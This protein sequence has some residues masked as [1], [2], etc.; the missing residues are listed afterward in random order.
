MPG[1]I[2]VGNVD[3]VAVLDMVPPAREPNMM[4]TTT[5]SQDWDSHQDC[6]E[7]G[8][9]QLYYLH[10]FLRSQGK[11]IMVDTGMGPGPHPDRGN[12]TGDLVNQLKSRGVETGDVD[13]VAHTHLHGDHVGW[14]VDYSGS[15]PAP[16]FPK[17]RYLVPRL[18]WE[19][20][21]KPD[22]IGSAPQVTNSVIPLEGMGVMDLVDS[23]YD[24]TDEVKTL[25]APGHT[26]GHM[27]IVITSQGEKAMVVGDLLH[28]KAQVVRPD[29]T[30]GV[31]TDKEASRSNRE[32]ILDD[33]EAEG[34]VIAAGHFHPDDHIG[35][36][37]RLDG[38]R[39]WQVL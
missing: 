38:R 36:V 17:A 27:V 6:L 7:E 12:R 11:V 4:F 19:H 33:A 16:T 18:D 9:L 14:N 39:Y 20:F 13:V 24:I 37:V 26:P 23:E 35:K 8:Q 29:W 1:R 21:T 34:F 2:T 10:F 28:S 15:Q 5:S 22:V 25:S 32:R 3:I 31:D 30:A